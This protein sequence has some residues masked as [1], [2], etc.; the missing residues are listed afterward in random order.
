MA[1]S[2]S[3]RSISFTHALAPDTFQT[4]RFLLSTFHSSS[5]A[6]YATRAYFT[7][8]KALS[9]LAITSL[10]HLDV[11]I[12]TREETSEQKWTF[13][14]RL[15]ALRERLDKAPPKILVQPPP[16][17]FSAAKAD[18]PW[19]FPGSD[20]VHEAMYLRR[21]QAA[22]TNFGGRWGGQSGPITTPC[23]SYGLT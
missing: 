5:F 6:C 22:Q 14:A 2:V 15:K 10:A 3:S 21:S 16:P 12:Q 23:T 17:T 20:T 9:R 13:E 11:V 8:T 18:R 1:S 4:R 19:S 7:S